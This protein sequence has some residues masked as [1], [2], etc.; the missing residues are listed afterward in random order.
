LV[1]EVNLNASLLTCF[2]PIAELPFEREYLIRSKPNSSHLQQLRCLLKENEFHLAGA[3]SE[4]LILYKNIRCK[5]GQFGTLPNFSNMFPNSNRLFSI[6]QSIDHIAS[7]R[8]SV[9]PDGSILAIANTK[10]VL[11][12]TSSPNSEFVPFSRIEFEKPEK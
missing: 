7:C 1:A 9:S 8:L 11:I 3:F 5:L 2:D 10:Q 6:E 12:Y 4:N